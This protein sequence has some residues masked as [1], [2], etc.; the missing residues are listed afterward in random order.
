MVFC[1]MHIVPS[2]LQLVGAMVPLHRVWLL[3]Y[4]PTAHVGDP[5]TFRTVKDHMDQDARGAAG[6]VGTRLVGT[7]G[8]SPLLCAL[9]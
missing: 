3:L 5:C 9:P 7:H 6:E 1:I 8:P 4:A 2:P